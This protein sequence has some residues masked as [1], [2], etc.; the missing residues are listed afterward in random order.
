[1]FINRAVILSTLCN[2]RSPEHGNKSVF[3][4]N[5]PSRALFMER[6]CM[7]DAFDSYNF[8]G[9]AVCPETSVQCND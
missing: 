7:L 9:C 4:S 8:M 1:M 6:T 2:I 3:D 5:R